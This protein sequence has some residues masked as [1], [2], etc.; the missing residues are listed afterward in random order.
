[1]QCAC[2]ITV[3]L[4]GGAYMIALAL[5]AIGTLGLFN[6]ER[7]PLAGVLLIPLGL[8]WN[9][10]LDAVPEPGLP[11]LIAAAPILNLVLLN[12][13]YRLLSKRSA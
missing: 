11:L 8:P 1:M 9:R 3:S 4:L 7:N 10:I 12:F 2:R 6:Q 13:A 5:F